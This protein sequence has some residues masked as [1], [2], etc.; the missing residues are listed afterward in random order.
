M[1]PV[2]SAPASTSALSCRCPAQAHVER[3]LLCST[4]VPLRP[5]SG[6][7]CRNTDLCVGRRLTDRKPH[8]RALVERS[9]PRHAVGRCLS[10]RLHLPPPPASCLFGGRSPDSP[11][12]E[13]HVSAISVSQPANVL[14]KLLTAHEHTHTHRS[15]QS[16]SKQ[17]EKQILFRYL[18][19]PGVAEGSMQLHIP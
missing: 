4:N 8:P 5:R 15:D 13:A 9:V 1:T 16:S 17:L 19:L 14:G 6:N 11:D 18:Q 7:D 3:S 10:H 12:P 2:T